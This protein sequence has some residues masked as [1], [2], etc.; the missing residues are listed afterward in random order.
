[1]VAKSTTTVFC[2]RNSV[3]ACSM[4]D[5]CTCVPLR[6]TL[7]RR[8][9]GS[10]RAGKDPTCLFPSR[11][12]TLQAVRRKRSCWQNNT[13][14]IDTSCPLQRVFP[15][16]QRTTQEHGERKCQTF[17]AVGRTDEIPL[18]RTAVTP[19][20]RPVNPAVH[21]SRSLPAPTCPIMMKGG[22]TRARAHTLWVCSL[23]LNKV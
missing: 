3:H 11:L 9:G 19:D 13:L 4:R 20:A 10:W 16:C 17:A 2:L 5:V 6:G 14:F 23:V 1:M 8:G 22:T 18:L 21:C 7:A 12:T 15:R